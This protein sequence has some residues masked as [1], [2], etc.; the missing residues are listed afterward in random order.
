MNAGA[1][2]DRRRIFRQLLVALIMVVL[3]YLVA[4]TVALITGQQRPVPEVDR[5]GGTRVTLSAQTPDGNALDAGSLAAAQQTIS[6]RLTGLGLRDAQVDVAG[7]DL[8]VTVPGEDTDK[9]TDIGRAG[10]LFLRPVLAMLPAQPAVPRPDEP[11]TLAEHIAAQKKSRQSLDTIQQ[12]QALTQ[13]AAGCPVDDALAGNDDPELPLVTC[14]AAGQQVYLLA[15]SILDGEK[16]RSAGWAQ[17]EQFGGYVVDLQLDSSGTETWADYTA[18]HVGNQTAF[19]LDSAVI[20]APQINEAMPGG[21]I[22]IS[23]NFT[24]EQAR[25]LAA[26]LNHRP[27]P[28]PFTTI[29]SEPV[30]PKPPKSVFASPE[31]GLI[32]IGVVLMVGL[33]AGLVIASMRGAGPL[34]R[35]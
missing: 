13:L 8:T 18:D 30:A 22:Q 21:R 16:I 3:A 33:I 25:Q 34:G 26:E 27:L 20:S 5:V 1:P 10:R 31:F 15:P 23:G 35:E 28:V 7:D 14:D 6:A 29:G 19:T 4:V 9:L 17:S 24:E 12:S 2:S 32:G 11:G